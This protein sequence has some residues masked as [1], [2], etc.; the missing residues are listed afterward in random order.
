MIPAAN[1]RPMPVVSRMIIATAN[2]KPS[3][4]RK[5]C[6][7]M[8]LPSSRSNHR[9]PV[10]RPTA[11]IGRVDDAPRKATFATRDH[12]VAPASPPIT[13]P[14]PSVISPSLGRVLGSRLQ[15]AGDVVSIA[16]FHARRRSSPRETAVH[17]T[18]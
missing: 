17:R 9:R 14:G 7:H 18:A 15:L 6:H 11:E 2:S 3:P 16:P 5:P 13:E 12:R 10:D 1:G 8:P 4:I